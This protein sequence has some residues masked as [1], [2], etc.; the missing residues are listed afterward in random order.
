MHVA[1]LNHLEVIT[2]G[3]LT[4]ELSGQVISTFN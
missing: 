4:F 2:I 1:G 3:D